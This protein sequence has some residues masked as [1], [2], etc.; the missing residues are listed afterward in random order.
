MQTTWDNLNKESLI[1]IADHLSLSDIASLVQVNRY[2]RY[3]LS[4]YIKAFDPL[5]D[6]AWKELSTPYAERTAKLEEQLNFPLKF[7]PFRRQ[8]ILDDLIL[9]KEILYSQLLSN[10]INKLIWIPVEESVVKFIEKKIESQ[11][12]DTALR[13]KDQLKAKL[14][15]KNFSCYQE[16]AKQFYK[17]FSVNKSFLFDQDKPLRE[18]LLILKYLVEF[19]RKYLNLNEQYAS[20][21]F[22][23]DLIAD[24]TDKSLIQNV[25]PMLVKEI[26]W[27]H[28]PQRLEAF[29]VFAR[30]GKDFDS[31][32][33]KVKLLDELTIQA[34][35]A[36]GECR[37]G[38]IYALVC[39]LIS[40]LS[41]EENKFYCLNKLIDPNGESLEVNNTLAESCHSL[42]GISLDYLAQKLHVHD[43]FDVI[44]DQIISLQNPELK[45]KLMLNLP[46]IFLFSLSSPTKPDKPNRLFIKD[47]CHDLYKNFLKDPALEYEY[48]WPEFDVD[49]AYKKYFENFLKLIDYAK[50]ITDD[51]N[52][53]LEFVE[54][55]FSSYK[56]HSFFEYNGYVKL[57]E[58]IFTL[59]CPR[60]KMT[61]MVY[62]LFDKM[63]FVILNIPSEKVNEEFDILFDLAKTANENLR[64]ELLVKLKDFLVC[65]LHGAENFKTFKLV[66]NFRNFLAFLEKF[67]VLDLKNC[68]P[69]YFKNYKEILLNL[70]AEIYL[71]LNEKSAEN[72]KKL[73]AILEEM[74]LVGSH[75]FLRLLCKKSKAKNITAEERRALPKF[76]LSDLMLR[77]VIQTSTARPDMDWSWR[78]PMR[79]RE[80]A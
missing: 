61:E 62:E 79:N 80:Y 46:H 57:R 29:K 33:A 14:T 32:K 9:H 53:K 64:I 18:K 26:S 8:Q 31:D 54:K 48:T 52:K 67:I 27:F 3:S 6:R 63:N 70:K 50:S 77:K 25:L 4:K 30:Y 58:L 36:Y 75:F 11:P 60:C 43:V 45:H 40:T 24:T 17:K 44:Y 34:G 42:R 65:S 19:K 1:N 41:I 21:I 7:G 28:S 74:K 71:S 16:N 73:C 66:K 59:S 78:E 13:L 72:A 51:Q 15:E 22:I 10:A 68:H 37:N 56:F 5:A 55:L 49:L 35:R 20:F 69:D 2:S 76:S 39:S 38:E 12:A 23:I 47:E